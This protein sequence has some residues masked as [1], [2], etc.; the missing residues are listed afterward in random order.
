VA[1][2]VIVTGAAGFIG[3]HVVDALLARGDVVVGIDNFDT[4]YDPDL[5]RANLADAM[6]H[7]SFEL[8]EADVRDAAAMRRIVDAFHP[9]A[10]VHL[11]A[12]AGVRPSIQDPALYAAV[13]VLGTTVLLEAA[14]AAKIARIIVASS[15][16][17]YG[18]DATPPFREDESAIRPISPYAVTKRAAE[19]MCE[20]Y[21]GL[22]DWMK[23]ISLRFFTVYGPRQRPDLAIRSFTTKI[24]AGESVPFFGDGTAERDYTYI[25]DTVQGVLGAVDRSRTSKPGHEIF[26]LGESAVTS[27]SALVTLIEQAL[28]MTAKLERLPAQP[29][30]VRRTLADISKARKYLG[31]APSV[32]VS[33]GI[34]RF[35]AWFRES[36]IG[37]ASAITAARG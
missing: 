34:P 33:D 4:F 30:D 1:E 28:G 7:P 12:R 14:R 18:N 31:Y 25:T 26:N 19:L 2:K 11:A 6:L 24:A 36:G 3:S 37:A 8:V 15:S 17:V 21:A 9:D 35:V 13:N 29:G 5:K 32:Q 23:I 22:F 27:L 16:S 20:S 10:I